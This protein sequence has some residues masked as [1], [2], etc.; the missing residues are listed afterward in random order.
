MLIFDLRVKS[1]EFLSQLSNI[2][3]RIIV[4]L[5]LCMFEQTNRKDLDR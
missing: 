1:K 5:Y 3:H 4:N 2:V